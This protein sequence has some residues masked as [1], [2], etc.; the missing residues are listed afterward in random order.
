MKKSLFFLFLGLLIGNFL[1]FAF[2]ATAQNPESN[3]DIEILDVPVATE[4]LEVSNSA[5]SVDNLISGI[6]FGL[7]TSTF[8]STE[9]SKIKRDI[10]NNREIISRLDVIISL[11]RKK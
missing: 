1:G 7:S 5:S 11:L 10:S 9:Q 8:T 6:D 3:E 2:I 4:E